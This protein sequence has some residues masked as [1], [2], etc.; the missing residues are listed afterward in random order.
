MDTTDE[1][2]ENGDGASSCHHL[3]TRERDSLEDLRV[4]RRKSAV[5]LTVITVAL[6][7][8]TM[9]DESW[10]R[11]RLE[12]GSYLSKMPEKHF[13][14]LFRMD[15]RTFQH[16]LDRTKHGMQRDYLQSERAG[17]FVSPEA[18]LAFT[19]RWL[20][21]GSYI[22][23]TDHYGVSR[24]TF[25]RLVY[26]CIDLIIHAFPISF[27]AV[28]RAALDSLAT[29]FVSKQTKSIFQRVVGAIDGILIKIRCPSARECHGAK[30]YWYLLPCACSPCP[31]HQ[32][33]RLLSMLD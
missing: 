21:G 5:L 3:K 29:D 7:A 2:D 12:W 31:L 23:I 10:K 22:D 28:S 15:Y 18:Q 30:N 20:A 8:N 13:F 24:S 26:E 1:E 25:Y 19:I 9:R 11:S 4:R 14:T 33:P 32:C 16:L 17:G 27:P 6:I